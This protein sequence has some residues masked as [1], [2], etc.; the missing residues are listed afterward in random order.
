MTTPRGRVLGGIAGAVRIAFRAGPAHLLASLLVALVEGVLPIASAWAT[1]V[2]LDGVVGGSGDG[3]VT[4]LVVLALAAT[5]MRVLP[6]TETFLGAELER[7]IVLSVQDALGRKVLGFRG[8]GIFEDPQFHDE[9]RMAQQ[10][11][12]AAPGQLVRGGTALLQQAVTLAG[13]LVTLL[14]IGPLLALLVAA[15][16]LPGL[17]AELSLSRHRVAM[18]FS[19]SPNERRRLFYFLLQNDVRA[20]RE[21]RVF[22]LG[23]LFHGRL[24]RELRTT[25]RAELAVDRRALRTQLALGVLGGAVIGVAFAYTAGQV[26][27]GALGVGDIALVLA[28]LAG[29]Q[30]SA[31]SIVTGIA[32]LSENLLLFDYFRRFLR[33]TDDLPTPA[34]PRPVPALRRGIEFRGVWF[35][36]REDLPWVLRGVD[37]TLTAGQATALVGSNGSGKTTLVKLLCRF[38][39]PTRGRILWDGVD[40]RD[41]DLDQLRRR[42]SVVLQDFM[43]YELGAGENIGLGDVERMDD[44]AAVAAAAALADVH[45]T[46]ARLP[47]GYDTL[48]TRMF[49]D[50]SVV[51][52][53]IVDEPDGGT[54]TGVTLSGGQ[55]QKISLARMFMRPDPDLVILDEPNAALDADA[56]HE[57]IRRF[58]DTLRDRTA[59]LISHR[60][61]TVLLADQI[62]VLDQGLV[63]EAGDHDALLRLDGT[64]ARMFRRQAGSYAT[65]AGPALP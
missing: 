38:Y 4:S 8:I 62:V 44:R 25:H 48:L 55:W 61:N 26:L 64:Y 56:E 21:I 34:E 32:A 1:K 16:A 9:L 57:I 17:W 35:R 13:F 12:E 23:G 53:G 20:A 22:G 50:M 51:Q 65:P 43:E 37:L 11:G 42:L 18:L 24:L 58:R 47:D 33:R 6:A 29:V 15:A 59:V 2:L 45:E 41:L 19:I 52:E 46:V 49:A 63:T 60:L 14:V 31:A 7:R 36:Y 10:G 54:G 27:D 3:V 28:G 39:D 40:L 30:G 5:A